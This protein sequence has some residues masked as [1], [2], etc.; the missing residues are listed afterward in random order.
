MKEKESVLYQLVLTMGIIVMFVILGFGVIGE[1]V[2]P[3]ERTYTN[4]DYQSYNQGWLYIS[5][6]GGSQD[7]ELPA[8]LDV[9]EGTTIV[10]E[11][12]LEIP[13][14]GQVYLSFDSTKHDVKAYVDGQLRYSYST[15]DT[16]P[17]GSFSAGILTFIPLTPEDNGST[18]TIE[19]TGDNNY[20]GVI[21]EM[22]IGSQLGITLAMIDSQKLELICAFVMILSGFVAFITGF[23]VKRIYSRTMSIGFAGWGAM[24]AGIWIVSESN[25]RQFLL[26]NY[27]V[28]AN[29][30]YLALMMLPFA[31]AM[32]AN[33]L[34]KKRYQQVYLLICAL[35]IVESVVSMLL[36]LTD[37]AD[38]TDSL[39]YTFGLLIATMIFYLIT[40]I[41]DMVTGKIREYWIEFIGI[42]IMI[43]AGLAQ[44][45]SYTR[46]PA[47]LNGGFICLGLVIMIV[48]AY[49]H[50]L[51]DIVAM[52][53]E[54][55]AARE[56]SAASIEFLSRMAHE[57]RT[58][59]NAILGM[60]MMVLKESSEKHIL[61]YARDVNGAGN[62]LLSIVNETLDLAKVHAGRIQVEP[63]EY[64]L[65]D[66]LRECYRLVIPRA[67]ASKLSFVVEV[68]DILPA[69]LKGDR[70]R[71]IQ[72]ITNLL[73]NAVKYTPAGRVT[74]SVQGKINDGQLMMA[75]SVTDTGIG[76]AQEN[77]PYIFDSFRRVVSFKDRKIEGTG[78]GLAITKQL[79]D[80][81]GGHIS[82]E[83]QLGK[84]SSFTVTLPQE[85][86][87]LEPCGIFSMGPNGDRRVRN[88]N[89]VLTVEGRILVVDDVDI[90]LKVFTLFLKNTSIKVDTAKSGQ[91]ALSLIEQNTYDLIFIDHLMPGMDGVELKEIIDTMV[92]NPNHGVPIIAQTANAM[93][94]AR[95]EYERMGFADYLAKPF[96]EE[97][98]RQLLKLYLQKEEKE[99]KENGI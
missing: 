87:C 68:D 18:I 6:E 32:Y 60:N 57:M 53:H 40:V 86:C 36:Q 89:E 17:F 23:L 69:R 27:S 88:R 51:R 13:G 43:A 7:I 58:P 25:V 66:M 33:A 85:I 95:E 42:V 91:E 61:E 98:L 11:N 15:E 9:E 71:L 65:I 44:M 34:Q 8:N 79:V 46:H 38:L 92:D 12:T 62:Y 28:A 55:F 26:G 96:K 80:L 21:D 73:T 84:G 48:M 82:V 37:R 54:L 31:F 78:L 49:I 94:G 77:I 41:Y 19:L 14:D 50:A 5:P 63:V 99:T 3:D 4:M 24:F 67:K 30:T 81:M 93:V 97:E 74:L 75:I 20:A 10:L 22:H 83:S 90:N 47:S 1:L 35:D 72:V 16:R 64:D 70:T 29:M 76:I 56:A 52:E 2:L 45:L 59:I 39:P